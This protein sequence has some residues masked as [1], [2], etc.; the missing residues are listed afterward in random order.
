MDEARG[1]NVREISQRQILHGIIYMRNLKPEKT[2]KQIQKP[3][4]H[5]Q[6]SSFEISYKKA[7]L[8]L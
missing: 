8:D 3:V 6:Y 5:S 1:P 4:I 7:G 2:K